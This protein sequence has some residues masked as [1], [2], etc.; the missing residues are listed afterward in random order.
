MQVED[1][2]YKTRWSRMTVNGSFV[3]AAFWRMRMPGG[4]RLHVAFHSRQPRVATLRRLA[5]SSEAADPSTC[6][7]LQAVTISSD[8]RRS[9]AA[10][11]GA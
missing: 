6:R 11:A 5:C 9:A 1:H 7:T 4:E 8:T 3:R 10:T 2:A